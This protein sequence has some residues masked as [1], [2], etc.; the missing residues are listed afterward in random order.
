MWRSLTP[1]DRAPYEK[2]HAREKVAF[3]ERSA[4]WQQS[5]EFKEIDLLER[6]Q[7]DAKRSEKRAKKE[8][9]EIEIQS[10]LEGGFQAQPGRGLLPGRTAFLT[11]L[12][13]Q[14]ALN[15]KEVKLVEFV[16]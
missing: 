9:E 6:L 2:L 10:L 7:K 12:T 4:V 15:G 8:A 11:G 14:T 16:Q 5:K 13:W 3:E 1:T